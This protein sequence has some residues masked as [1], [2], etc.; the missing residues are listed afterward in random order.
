MIGSGGHALALLDAVRSTGGRPP[1][2]IVDLE[3]HRWGELCGTHRVLGG[4]SLIASLAA[5]GCRRC[6][7]GAGDEGDLEPR[8]RAAL[9]AARFRL[10]MLIV[11]H[12][13][14]VV[15]DSARLA[16]GV[17][18]MAGAVV[19]PDSELSENVLINAAAVVQSR[20]KVG[21][22]S[23][24]ATGARLLGGAVVGERSH[25]GA[26]TIVLAGVHIGDDCLVGPGLVIAQSMPSGATAI[27]SAPQII[28]QPSWR[29]AG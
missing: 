29:L 14:A 19:C 5:Q 17:Q 21:T 1:R 4:E 25:I 7:I 27:G 6:V 26:G 10:Q 13:S 2:A 28:V 22:H 12:A 23:H 11:R 24:V 20:A 18:I 8:R 16:S 9:A 15:A 3:E